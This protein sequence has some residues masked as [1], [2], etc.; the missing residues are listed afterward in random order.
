VITSDGKLV[1]TADGV[2]VMMER[3]TRRPLPYA[4]A[5][6]QVLESLLRASEG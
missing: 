5:T 3:A 4:D 1:A 2:V 6:R